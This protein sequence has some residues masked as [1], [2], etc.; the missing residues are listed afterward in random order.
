MEEKK[1]RKLRITEDALKK[2]RSMEKQ[3]HHFRVVMQTETSAL[4]RYHLIQTDEIDQADQ[5]L[6]DHGVPLYIEQSVLP[7]IETLEIGIQEDYNEDEDI[8]TISETII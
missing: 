3:G 6:E 4:P 5:K 1:E 8:F 2:M 7:Y